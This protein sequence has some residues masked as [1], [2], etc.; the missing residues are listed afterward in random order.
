V[1][2]LGTIP[3]SLARH[4]YAPDKWSVAEVLCH[5]NDCER[6]YTMRAFWFGRGLESPLPSF[7]SEQVVVTA[8]PHHLPLADH[9]GE[10]ADIRASTVRFFRNLPDDAWLRQGT[11]SGYP[12]TVR[13]LAWI[14]AGHVIHHLAVLRERYLT[15]T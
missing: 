6:L 9:V 1:S 8:R 10:F 3:E 15:G 4:R 12:F 14:A 2:F 7:E 11:A 13:A 5:L